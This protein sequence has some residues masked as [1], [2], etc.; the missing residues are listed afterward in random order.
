MKLLQIRDIT[1]KRSRDQH[2]LYYIFS[3]KI[4]NRILNKV[5]SRICLNFK[6]ALRVSLEIARPLRT[7]TGAFHNKRSVP[8]F[9]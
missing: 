9:F 2:V 4:L 3:F 7:H 5:K 1:A 6:I 8:E